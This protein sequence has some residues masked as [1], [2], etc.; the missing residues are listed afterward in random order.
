MDLALKL[1]LTDRVYTS[2][3]DLIK[4]RDKWVRKINYDI[5]YEKLNTLKDESISFLRKYLNN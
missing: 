2:P 3:N 5:V 4:N 1:G